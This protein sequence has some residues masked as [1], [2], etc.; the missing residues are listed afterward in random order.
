[1]KILYAICNIIQFG[2]SE[3]LQSYHQD[4]FFDQYS[5]NN[6]YDK[7]TDCFCSCQ[8][9]DEIKSC[10]ANVCPNCLRTV[11]NIIV[12]PYIIPYYI[13][14]QEVTTNKGKF[15]IGGR[16]TTVNNDSVTRPTAKD[17]IVTKTTA[18]ADIVTKA[19]AKPE[20]VTKA[21]TKRPGTYRRDND[22]IVFNDIIMKIKPNSKEKKIYDLVPAKHEIVRKAT[23]KRPCT[24]NRDTD[25]IV[26]NDIL[27]RKPNSKEKKFYT[28]VPIRRR[29]PR[30]M[31][32]KSIIITYL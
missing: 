25:N 11:H 6:N 20:I 24:Y 5:E 30:L 1:M 21:T 18:K 17:D 22:N 10:C 23:T 31:A 27:K 4:Q 3:Y 8:N 16:K 15:L 14:Q 7:I 19:T 13:R 9:C 32:N 26:F 12:V 2:D 28:L 29:Q